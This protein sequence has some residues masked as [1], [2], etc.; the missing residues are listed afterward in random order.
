MPL[1]LSKM[2]SDQ[3]RNMDRQIYF[4]SSTWADHM[5]ITFFIFSLFYQNVNIY[6]QNIINQKSSL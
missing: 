6:L 3:I 1:K 2:Q 5:S 4:A